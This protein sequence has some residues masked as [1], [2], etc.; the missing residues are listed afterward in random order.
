MERSAQ[1]QHQPLNPKLIFIFP[2]LGS[3][4]ARS[5]GIRKFHEGFK[6]FSPTKRWGKF[7]TSGAAPHLIKWDQ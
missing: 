3:C 5:S 4:P 6:D 1:S 7:V 2:L